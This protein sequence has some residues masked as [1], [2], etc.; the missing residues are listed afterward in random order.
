MGQIHPLKTIVELQKKGVPAGIYSAC[1]ANE[2]V[3][4]ACM[5]QAM[6]K[7]EYV[8]IEATANQVNQYGGYTGMKP[9][10]FKQ[11]VFSIADRVKF[12]VNKI[13]L[14]GDHLGPLTWSGLP[15]E[16][17]MAQ[18]K[19]LV[20]QFVLA[21]F[22]KIHIDTSMHLGDDDAGRK[23]ETSVIAERGAVLGEMAETAYK[24]L[25][26]TNPEAMQ[27]VY[28]IGSEVPI[29]GGSQDEEE[30]LQV[31]TVSDFNE[32][33]KVFKEAFYQHGL[34]D[35]WENVVAIVVQPGVEFGD[36]SI[37]EYN[38]DAAKAL[39]K[40]L[41]KLPNLVFEGHST[42]YQ[43]A[44]ALKAMVEDGIAILKVGPALT[45]ALREA[46]FALNHVENELLQ[47][48]TDIQPSRFIEVLEEVMVKRPENWIKHYHGNEEKLRLARKY[49]FSDRCRYYLPLPEVRQALDRMM[50]NLKTVDIPLSLLSQYMPVQYTRIREG[51]LTKDPVSLAK[52]RVVNCID[53]YL[54]G[55]QP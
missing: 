49:S 50:Q 24:E 31:T 17:A 38:R 48:R 8:L 28:V 45:F 44:E 21:G 3:L 46:L 32:T 55:T 54:Y 42:D 1:S 15:A 5:E 18:A 51:L 7:S 19:E 11:F 39:C 47:G 37:H 43:T 30:E 2:L 29:P 52:D 10:D 34:K 22:T 26:A 35:V 14:G 36:D 33:V 41:D 23:L 16:E 4:E 27:P 40:S 12:P 6:K 20:R 53:E 9:S 25:V 13:I